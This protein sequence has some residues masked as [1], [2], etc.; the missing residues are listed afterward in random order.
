MLYDLAVMFARYHFV[1][2]QV[3]CIK[4]KVRFKFFPN[5]V[6][7]N[8]NKKRAQMRPL[9]DS[10]F[11]LVFVWQVSINPDLQVSTS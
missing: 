5:V 2:F 8:V 10:I 4:F 3:I 11:N 1:Y 6:D 7:K 9:W